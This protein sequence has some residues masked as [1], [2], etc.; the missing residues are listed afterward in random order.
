M[1]YF[2]DAKFATLQIF[3]DI[4]SLQNYLNQHSDK[5][6]GFVPT[7]GAL[8]DAHL[9]LIEAANNQCDITVCSI[10]VNPKQFNK[11]GDLDNY[12]RDIDRDITSL[13]SVNCDVLFYP[14]VEEMYP[15]EN[16][17]VFD[18]GD[19]TKLMEGEFRPGHFNGV[20]LV[21]E[22]FFEIINPTYAY[23][24][25]K[26]FQQLAVINALVKKINSPVKVVGCSTIREESG[27][28]MSS[29]NERLTKEEKAAAADI[30]KALTNISNLSKNKSIEEVKNQYIATI[31]SNP[32][33]TTEYIEIADA[34]TLQPIKDWSESSQVRAF[35]AVNIRDVRLI[36]NIAINN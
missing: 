4:S 11:Q 9:T 1:G 13:E 7:M 21:I 19:L 28:A 26:D 22:R 6:I 31:N 16:N 23:F 3:K 15:S 25:E 29:R 5:N 10:F 27:L 30:F 36:D 35:T 33:L 14:S 2:A 32:Y 8:H 17:K 18:F 20:A 34:N 24:G 12:P